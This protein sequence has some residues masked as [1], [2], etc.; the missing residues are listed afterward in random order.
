MVCSSKMKDFAHEKLLLLQAHCAVK[1]LLRLVFCFKLHTKQFLPPECI[2]AP[3][4]G[5][6]QDAFS[7]K[8][9]NLLQSTTQ[10]AQEKQAVSVPQAAP[11]QM[12][13]P[14]RSETEAANIAYG[15]TVTAL[16]NGQQP[17]GQTGHALDPARVAALLDF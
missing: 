2:M 1:K 11:A 6:G 10:K 12:A 8:L 13:A 7:F 15:N 4:E 17:A 9:G 14:V 16:E 3:I 5:I